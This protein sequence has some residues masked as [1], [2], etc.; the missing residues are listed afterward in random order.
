[1]KFINKYKSPNFNKRKKGS[2]IKLIILHYTAMKSSSEAIEYLCQKKNKVSSHFLINKKGK[3]FNLVNLNLRAWHAGKSSWKNVKDINSY[4]I[5]IEIDNSGINL[6]YEQ[7]PNIQI[8]FLIKLINFLKKKYL[9]TSN[10]ILAHSD[11]APYRKID[12]GDKFPWH[13]FTNFHV[14][15][16]PKNIDIKFDEL[17]EALFIKNKLYNMKDK[18]LFIL[19]K[20]GYNIIPAK[21]NKKNF[22]ILIKS[23]QMHFSKFKSDGFLDRKTYN[24]LVNHLKQLLTI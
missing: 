2:K 15:T 20:V 12:P 24:L 14:H 4:S 22:N 3:I 1:M 5:G 23:Y 6:D 8:S 11:V 17:I 9:I 19:S 16:F 21:K 18:S 13:R 10:N 7:Y